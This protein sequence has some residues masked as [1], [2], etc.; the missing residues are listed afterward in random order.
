M[1]LEPYPNACYAAL[2]MFPSVKCDSVCFL[3]T[4]LG[5]NILV[6]HHV[7]FLMALSTTS[8]FA[9]SATSSEWQLLAE[10]SVV[11]RY[12]K[13]PRSIVAFVCATTTG[14][15]ATDGRPL[16]PW[17]LH[18]FPSYM[19]TLLSRLRHLTLPL[20]PFH[21]ILQPRKALLPTFNSYF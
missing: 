20:H 18:C 3:S 21:T 6:A 15:T 17:P 10:Q 12:S 13:L 11:D 8:A 14:P 5:C 19:Y 1:G 2:N 4:D 7:A 9:D 16:P